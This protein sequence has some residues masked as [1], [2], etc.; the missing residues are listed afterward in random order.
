MPLVQRQQQRHQAGGERQR[1]AQVERLRRAAA[2]IARHE[3]QRQRQRQQPHGQVDVEHRPP[4]ERRRQPA[5]D[6]W[7]NRQPQVGHRGLEP[8]RPP[9]HLG[10]EGFGEDRRRVGEEH[11][12]TQGLRSARADQKTDV[13]RQAAQ[14]RSEQEHGE[15]SGVDRPVPA[16]VAEPTDRQEQPADDQQVDGDDPLD[17]R[18]RRAEIAA[19]DGQDDVDHAAVERRHEGAEPDGQQDAPAR[20]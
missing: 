19:H 10:R 11:G 4:A 3:A 15:A 18:H 6:R 17:R 16:Q 2:L 5:T 7:A 13:R 14:R 12:R 1:A 9:A 8:E 20:A